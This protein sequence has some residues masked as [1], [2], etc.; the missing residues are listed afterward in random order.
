MI[1]SHRSLR[2]GAADRADGP[3]RKA[4]LGRPPS[5]RPSC[6][7]EVSVDTAPSTHL[8]TLLLLGMAGTNSVQTTLR[9]HAIATRSTTASSGTATQTRTQLLACSSR[10]RQLPAYS[11]RRQLRQLPVPVHKAQPETALCVQGAVVHSRSPEPRAREEG[12]AT[13]GRPGCR[14]QADGRVQQEDGGGG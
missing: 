8:V 9:H 2:Q 14:A 13:A 6:R 12:R 11:S 5:R 4:L 3:Q 10:R 7:P 1:I